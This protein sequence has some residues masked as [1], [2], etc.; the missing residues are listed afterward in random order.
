MSRS[1]FD[2]HADV[3]EHLTRLFSQLDDGFGAFATELKA[4]GVWNNV[5]LIQTSDFARTLNPNGGDGTDHAWGGNYIM[6][7]GAVKGG[8]IL[9]EYPEDITDDGPLTLGRGRMIPTTPWDAAFRGIA[10][11]LGVPDR[12]M[13][14]VCPNLHNFDSTYLIE[15]DD[16]FEG[17]A[18]RTRAPSAF[19]TPFPTEIPSTITASPR[20]SDTPTTI[21][22]SQPSVHLSTQPSTPPSE[23]S[24][25]NCEDATSNFF[26]VSEIGRSKTCE[27]AVRIPEKKEERCSYEAVKEN[28]CKSCC[29]LTEPPSTP[30]SLS[31]SELSCLTC[32]DTTTGNFYVNEVGRSKNCEWAIRKNKEERCG[33]EA[34]KENCCKS[35]CDLPFPSA[36]PSS[37]PSASPAPSIRNCP[38]NCYGDARDGLFFVA[39]FGEQ[40][41]A[42]A[43]QNPAKKEERC[44]Y[45]EVALNCCW[46]CCSECVADAYGPGE[47][48]IIRDVK[49]TCS[50]VV[51]INQEKR[52]AIEP[53]AKTCCKSCESYL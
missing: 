24:C 7:G 17:L 27:W 15:P 20:P 33:Y 38:S 32:E 2:T 4:M 34:V 31:P 47:K 53:A 45:P 43:I 46:S 18:N 37:K 21:P 19:P 23:F 49:K 28:C 6:M 26:W 42:W 9:G 13:S 14:E 25:L 22:S 12:D 1:G 10:T 11:W 40:D 51:N 44:G 35:C 52:C 29:S 8:Q 3:E 30:P 48:F 39:G 36:V 50:W 5:T 41:C 16:M